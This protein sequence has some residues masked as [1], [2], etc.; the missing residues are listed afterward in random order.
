MSMNIF[1]FLQIELR[2]SGQVHVADCPFCYSESKFFMDVDTTKYECKKCGEKGNNYTLITKLHSKWLADT[3]P[4]HYQEISKARGIPKSTFIKAKVAYHD[5]RYY[6][7]YFRDDNGKNLANLGVT[8]ADTG[9]P[10]SSWKIFKAPGL[11]LSI[12]HPIQAKL[13]DTVYICEGEWDALALL[14]YFHESS[15]VA[16]PGCQT[17]KEDWLPKFDGKTVVILY[18]NDDPG[19][20]GAIKVCKLL[21]TRVASIAYLNWPAVHEIK[22]A[23][24]E[25]KKGKDIRD[26][27]ISFKDADKISTFISENL[28]TPTESIAKGEFSLPTLINVKSWNELTTIFSKELYITESSMATLSCAFSSILSCFM[29]GEPLWFFFVGPPS[30]GKTTVIEAFG[31]KNKYCEDR[32]KLTHTTLVSGMKDG[33]E[34][35]PSLFAII[36]RRMLAVKDWTTVIEQNH[37]A[38]SELYSILRD[39]FDGNYSATYGNRISRRYE[40][41]KFGFIA[42]VTDAIYRDS[43]SSLGERFMKIHFMDK[44]FDERQHIVA[45]ITGG[46]RKIE[47]SQTLESATLGYLDFLVN[48]LAKNKIY[49]VEIYKPGTEELTDAI[50]DII[51]LA[52][53]VSYMRTNVE[54]SSRDESIMYRPQK[55]VASRLSSQFTKLAQALFYIFNFDKDP[56][57]Q[58]N[59]RK[60][61][62]LPAQLYDI[63][64]RVAIDTCIPFNIELINCVTSYEEFGGASRNDIIDNLQIPKTNIHRILLDLQQLNF[65]RAEKFD[66]PPRKGRPSELYKFIP[67]LSQLWKRIQSKG[68]PYLP[69][70]NL[71][72]KKKVKKWK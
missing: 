51:D 22:D 57:Y 60:I 30:S 61:Y 2:P 9:G 47:R 42:G 72:P 21:S 59:E 36:N 27:V 10:K 4:S 35:D 29:E 26:L 23:N 17:F 8:S 11:S 50:S 52:H 25:T 70:N 44:H 71:T 1:E 6:I 3:K 46:R 58:N 16:A 18:D 68:S 66:G 13:S 37:T 14:P 38:Q 63:L 69:H 45:A 24:D 62:T 41:L 65:I 19:K 64:R 67:I 53:F 15:V 33:N 54:R 48:N 32:S 55:E 43:K 12:Y 7:P 39:A 28:E 49:E 20:K 34:E 5:G 31:S 56:N 40:S